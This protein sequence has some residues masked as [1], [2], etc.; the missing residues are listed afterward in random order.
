MYMPVPAMIQ[1]ITAPIGPVA[2]AKVRGSEKMPAPTMPPTTIAVRA[3]RVI[4]CSP[5]ISAPSHFGLQRGRSEV[6][7]Q[8]DPD[9]G[10]TVV[11]GE[12]VALVADVQDFRVQ[13]PAR[14]K[15]PGEPAAGL[16]Q[17]VVAG[18]DADQ[19][20]TRCAEPLDVVAVVLPPEEGEAA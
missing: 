10:R 18:A 13:R 19:A 7:A 2:L 16:V 20:V 8:G 9:L 14:R 3:I 15:L 17:V 5:A 11:S 1:A 4:F 6:P 12:D